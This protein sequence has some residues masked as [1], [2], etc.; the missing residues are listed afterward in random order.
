MNLETKDLKTEPSSVMAPAPAAA[1]EGHY[2][3]PS[4]RNFRGMIIFSAVLL[5]AFFRPLLA[6]LEYAPHEELYSHILLIP[7]ITGYLIWARRKEPVPQ[8]RPN[9]ALAVFPLAVGLAVLGIYAFGLKHGWQYETPDY[10]AAMILPLLCFLL[11]GAFLFLQRSYLKSITFPI[12]VLVFCVPFPQAVRM[13]IEV[14]FQHGSAYAAYGMLM[15][16]RMPVLRTNTAFTMPGF[17]LDVQPECSGIH[18]SLVLLITST[19]AAYL[20]LR[21]PYHRWLFILCIVPLAILRNGFRVWSLAEIG[22]HFNPLILDT[23]F[24]HHGGPLFFLLSLIPLFLFLKFL[25]RCEA[26]KESLTT[27]K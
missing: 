4:W 11:A 14:F 19:L 1:A 22:V 26:R 6:L 5:V 13:G 15:L 20:F 10:L 25:I 2:F 12:A 27:G 8:S 23:A 18:S 16:T 21:S 24:H 9:R 3:I 7:F 17:S